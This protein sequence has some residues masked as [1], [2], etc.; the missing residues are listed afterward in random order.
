MQYVKWTT[1]GAVKG[2][3]PSIPRR[4]GCVKAE[5]YDGIPIEAGV[6]LQNKVAPRVIALVLDI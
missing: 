6:S 5:E 1:E 4:T 3:F 2:L